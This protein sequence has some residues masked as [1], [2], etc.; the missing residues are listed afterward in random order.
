MKNI[1]YNYTGQGDNFFMNKYKNLLITTAISLAAIT[2]IVAVSANSNNGPFVG[3]IG[4]P[5]DKARVITVDRD[6]FI[7]TVRYK[8]DE[9]E[10][11]G[12]NSTSG[13][14]YR[15]E[16]GAYGYVFAMQNQSGITYGNNC[17]LAFMAKNTVRFSVN[18]SYGNGKI[19]YSDYECTQKMDVFEFRHLTQ[20]DIVLDN[21]ESN[22]LTSKFTV[23]EGTMSEGVA[24]EENKCVRYTWTGDVYIGS[25]LS[26]TAEKTSET[27]YYW[28]RSLTFHYVC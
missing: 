6:N 14:F 13:V 3:V 24:D 11:S 23:S 5:L 10:V 27:K 26:F 28:V 15:L 1:R 12:R 8:N 7:N 16:D 4:D 21:S 19:F 22:R 25:N 18:S 20:I 17:V 9:E 2:S